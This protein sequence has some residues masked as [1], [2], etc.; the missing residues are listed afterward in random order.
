M[1]SIELNEIFR[2]FLL[3]TVKHR[4]VELNETEQFSKFGK[5]IEPN[6]DRTKRD[7]SVELVC[8]TSSELGKVLRQQEV[9]LQSGEVL[10]FRDFLVA[11]S[12]SEAPKPSQIKGMRIFRWTANRLS[13]STFSNFQNFCKDRQYDIVGNETRAWTIALEK[14]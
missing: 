11:C 12:S 2:D 7:M 5:N 4:I 13:I 3:Q 9:G 8:T 1:K 14:S 10:I 6:E